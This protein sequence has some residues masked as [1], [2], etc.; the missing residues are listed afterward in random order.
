[1]HGALV[2]TLSIQ[3]LAT[4]SAAAAGISHHDGPTVVDAGKQVTYQ[5][6]NR[7]GIEIFLNIP[8]G[9]DTGGLNRFRPPH[10]YEPQPGS[11]ISA[12]S[13]GSACPQPLG[14]GLP[15]VV[16][17]NVT[18]ISEDCLN[19]NVARP[20]GACAD[21]KLPVL[22]FI[23]GGGFWEGQNR[24]ITTQPDG[25]ILESAKNGLPVIEVGIQYRLGCEYLPMDVHIHS[26]CV[27]EVASELT[28]ANSFWLRFLRCPQLGGIRQRG[29][30][31]PATGHRM[32]PR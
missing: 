25:M 20:K 28:K 1:M 29:L 11:T 14:L 30:A 27:S 13:Y 7:N 12:T 16:L 3:V 9:R 21:D 22:L 32:G 15:P 24:E 5:G 23:H 18:D 26:S 4:A 2:L 31:R 17:T 6:L 19:L 8:Y 10:A